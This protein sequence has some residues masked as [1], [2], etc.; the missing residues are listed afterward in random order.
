M[1]N[2]PRGRL[3]LRWIDCFEN[4]LNVFKNQKLVNSCQKYRCLEKNSGEGQGPPRAEEPLKKKLNPSD[5]KQD[6]TLELGLLSPSTNGLGLKVV[7]EVGR[8]YRSP[9][10]YGIISFLRFVRVCGGSRTS[11]TKRGELCRFV[12]DGMPESAKQRL[13][14]LSLEPELFHSENL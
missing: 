12:K 14:Q 11:K 1:G 6:T 10:I 5:S 2:G 9:L 7:L 3:P 8:G 13:E 4:N